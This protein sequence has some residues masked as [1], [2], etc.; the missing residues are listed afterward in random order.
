MNIGIK[1]TVLYA[2]ILKFKELFEKLQFYFKRSK[3]KCVL[4]VSGNISL[5]LKYFYLYTYSGTLV[6]RRLLQNRNICMYSFVLSHHCLFQTRKFQISVP[7][8]YTQWN[9]FPWSFSWK[10]GIGGTN[11]YSSCILKVSFL[12]KFSLSREQFFVRLFF[13][14]F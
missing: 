4:R 3:K 10:N 5:I 14:K 11:L 8:R 2:N 9:R 13:A 7:V 6:Q 1:S 12:K